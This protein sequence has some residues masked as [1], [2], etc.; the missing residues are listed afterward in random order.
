M[1]AL[2]TEHHAGLRRAGSET[3]VLETDE[4][5]V[6]YGR[7]TAVDQV[8]MAVAPGEIYGLLGPNGAGKTS[9]IRALTTIVA[10]HAGSATINGHPLTNPTAIRASI[11]V[12]P[13]SNGYPSAQTGLSYL[14]FYG[15]LFGLSR[16]EADVAAN[17]LLQ[18]V[19]LGENTSRIGTFS[20]GMRQRLGLARALINRPAVLFLDE[21]TLG[22]DPA[23][24]E[25]MMAYLTQTAIDDGTCVILCSHLLDEVERVCDRVA[26]M[27][28]AR[29]V[30]EGTVE[31]VINT[32]GV[33]GYGRVRISPEDVSAA[34]TALEASS[35]SVS[36]DFDN[37]RP[38]DLEIELGP[39]YGARSELLRTLLDAGVEVR[40]FDLQG[41]RL[42]DAFL[43]LTNAA[44]PQKVLV[45]TP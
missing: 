5:T 24:K 35:S 12:L 21:P 36:I 4:L 14:R 17:R 13:E 38:G 39:Q 20:R 16:V 43:A 6:R 15:Q 27:D 9:V 8:S 19:G 1:T 10:V 7:F 30:A 25:E 44:N 42:S 22:L 33:S 2:S 37:T 31:D 28:R 40:A 18:Q 11:G 41:A 45:Q 3:W 23:G 29:V 26:I 32:A 34:G